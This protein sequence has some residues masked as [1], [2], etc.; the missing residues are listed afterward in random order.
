MLKYRKRLTVQNISTPI[1]GLTFIIVSN[2]TNKHTCTQYINKPLF[3]DTTYRSH[4]FHLM[5]FLV[6]ETGVPG[7][8]K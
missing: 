7:E 4:V 6:H 5:K 3:R 8:N 1:L 2:F